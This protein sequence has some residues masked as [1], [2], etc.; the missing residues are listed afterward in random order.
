MAVQTDIRV[1]RRL[2]AAT[3]A[4]AYYVVSEALTNVSKHARASLAQVGAAMDGAI[5]RICVSDNGLGGADASRGTG[6]IGIDD[7]VQ[8][9]GG[10]LSV[11]SR[12]GNGTTICCE[13]PAAGIGD[14]VPTP[15]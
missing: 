13:L 11:S 1:E 4:C 2:P 12:A 9:L 14:D 10:T 8:A 15:R 3:E 6:L 7:R 5:L